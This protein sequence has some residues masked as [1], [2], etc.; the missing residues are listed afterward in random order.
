MIFDAI[1]SIYPAHPA[2]PPSRSFNLEIDEYV[3]LQEISRD[4]ILLKSKRLGISLT[5]TFNPKNP[6]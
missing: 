2:P 1:F 6:K 3:E 4:C 5:L